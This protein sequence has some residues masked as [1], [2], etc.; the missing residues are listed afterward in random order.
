MRIFVSLLLAGALGACAAVPPAPETYPEPSAAEA[1]RGDP[2]PPAPTRILDRD[3]AHRLRN[4]S[5]ITLQWIGWDERGH[6]QVAV[7][8][9]GVWRLS[10]MQRGAEGMVSVRGVVTEIGSDHFLLDGTVRIENTPDRGR[11][12][13]RDKLWRFAVTQNRKYWRLRE[14]EWCDYLTDYVDIYF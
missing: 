8:E 5:G 1:E 13:E 12:C 3:T 7:G 4:N 14:F 6:V 11:L 10:G 9:D 2:A